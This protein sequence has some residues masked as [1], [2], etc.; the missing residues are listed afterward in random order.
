MEPDSLAAY[1]QQIFESQLGGAADEQPASPAPAGTRAPP[2]QGTVLHGAPSRT[3]P[4]TD[5]I[6]LLRDRINEPETVGPTRNPTEPYNKG[7]GFADVLK[8]LVSGTPAPPA[9][10]DMYGEQA[11]A[12][13]GP[14]PPVASPAEAPPP[15][16]LPPGVVMDDGK[17][18]MADQIQTAFSNPPPQYGATPPRQGV[19][20]PQP[21]AQPVP[22]RPQAPPLTTTVNREPPAKEGFFSANNLRELIQ[23][24]ARGGS[25]VKPG[26]GRGAAAVAGAAGAANAG[27]RRDL[28]REQTKAANNKLLLDQTLK[29][30]NDRRAENKDAREEAARPGIDALRDATTRAALARAIKV[31]N[32]DLTAE[33]VLSIERR[34]GEKAKL[35]QADGMSGDKLVAKVEE[36]KKTL[37]DEVR[38][39]VKKGGA[40][41]TKAAPSK[42]PQTLTPQQIDELR[43]G[44]ALNGYRIKPDKLKNDPSTWF[45]SGDAWEQVR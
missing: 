41:Q 39:T 15:A 6:G 27:E 2:P 24:V 38:K 42:G 43:K 34:V 30:R 14:A 11:R 29:L 45:K 19:G 21:Q 33:H 13:R 36:Y 32:P 25:A 26:M 8:G 12:G 4:A 18:G 5:I 9:G 10:Y 17:G 1:L 16:P 40:D 44:G 7:G 3:G 37:V 23:D 35:Y 22:Q 20:G 28:L 31:D